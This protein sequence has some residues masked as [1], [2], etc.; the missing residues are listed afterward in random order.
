MSDEMKL[1]QDYQD[2][3]N[4]VHAPAELSR[5]V[6][7][8]ARTENKKTAVSFA[9]RFAAVAAIALTVFVG[10]NG[11]AYA[12]TG[13]SLLKTVKV[14][15]NGS[16]YET[17]LEE[18]VDENG[19]T[20]Y[21]GTFEDVEGDLSMVI[22]DD[23]EFEEGSYDVTIETEGVPDVVEENG[24][25]YL[26]DGDVKID[27]TDDLKDG[28]ASGS[29]DKDEMTFKY[30]VTEKDGTWDLSISNGEIKAE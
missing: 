2:T 9:R 29:Y 25:I 22:T 23:M 10:G 14:Y 3:F 21:E 20:Y 11:I 19:V 27:I 18:E 4:E 26:T 7:N 8:M 12:A 16:G 30:E 28:K 5:K 15:I 1:K 24:K 17:Q 6:M 13:N